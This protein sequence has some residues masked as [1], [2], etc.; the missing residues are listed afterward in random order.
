M[1][2]VV[3]RSL[4]QRTLIW[5]ATFVITAFIANVVIAVSGKPWWVYAKMLQSHESTRGRVTHIEPTNHLRIYFT[6]EVGSQSLVGSADGRTEQP[7]QPVV[8]YFR[9]GRPTE[10]TLKE[11]MSAFLSNLLPM[12]VA[13]A[14]AAT[15]VCWRTT[16]RPHSNA[17]EP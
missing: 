11:P 5:I 8:V 15:V 16:C 9:T 3:S 7:G 4:R 14:F 10:Y 6:Y 17:I 2:Q 1:R 13:C 12:L